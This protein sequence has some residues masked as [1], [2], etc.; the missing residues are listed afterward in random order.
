MENP[1]INKRLLYD[2]IL[3]YAGELKE[4]VHVLANERNNDGMRK[5]LML[6]NELM[7][8]V[9]IDEFFEKCIN[10]NCKYAEQTY[11]EQMRRSSL[12]ELN[13]IFGSKCDIVAE[14]ARREVF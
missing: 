11:F 14:L 6:G 4:K 7:D 5:L 3:A 12:A 10:E 9:N 8:A 2:S 1:S 13:Q